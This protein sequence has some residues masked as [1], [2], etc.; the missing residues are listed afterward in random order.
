MSVK[1]ARAGI[2]GFVDSA[3]HPVKR[4]LRRAPQAGRAKTPACAVA[5][6]RIL[7]DGSWQEE[8]C[9]AGGLPECRAT[10]D[11]AVAEAQRLVLVGWPLE[12]V[13]S[14]C[15]QHDFRWRLH[16]DTQGPLKVIVEPACPITRESRPGTR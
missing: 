15:L 3:A 6:L 7:P 5:V 10:A 14:W 8:R 1:V 2:A 13:A 16:P 4:V 9:C 11:Q 12:E